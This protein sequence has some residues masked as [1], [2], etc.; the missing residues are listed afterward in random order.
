MVD[1]SR[2]SDSAQAPDAPF[3]E[4]VILYLGDMLGE[5]RND[6][7]VVS[8]AELRQQA[9]P[10][11]QPTRNLTHVPWRERIEHKLEERHDAHVIDDEKY[12]RL[13]GAVGGLMEHLAAPS[14]DCGAAPASDEEL[15]ACMK[16]LLAEQ[17]A[18]LVEAWSLVLGTPKDF[19]IDAEGSFCFVVNLA[20]IHPKRGPIKR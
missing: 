5:G 12:E 9:I 16:E 8:K 18:D 14:A 17:A 7:V 6:Y 20:S 1:R 15:D 4:H 11:E 13:K 10:L 3:H 2:P 19:L